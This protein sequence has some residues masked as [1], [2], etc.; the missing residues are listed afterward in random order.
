MSKSPI[1]LNFWVMPNAG[2]T[3]RLILE[4]EIKNFQKR[5]PH[6]HIN[7]TIHPWSKAWDALMSFVKNKTATAAP[8]IVQIGSTWSGT[9]TYLGVLQNITNS[10][11]VQGRKA[12]VRHALESGFYP[13]TD[14]LYSIPWFLDIRVLYFRHDLLKK[15]KKEPADLDTWE[16]FR[17]VC[18]AL[19]KLSKKKSTLY[20]LRL[21]G[22][23]AGILVHDIAPWIWGAGGDFLSSDRK[24]SQFSN[25]DAFFGIQWYFSLIQSGI[26]P[27]ISK[28]GFVPPGNFFSGEYAMQFSGI[29]PLQIFTNPRVPDYNATVAKEYGVALFPRGRAG[30]WTFF[31]GSNLGITS[32]SK[33]PAEATEFMQYLVSS[34]SQE[35]H[36][37]AIGMFPSVKSAF[38]NMAAL[39]PEVGSVFRESL[40]IAR[41]LPSILSLGTIEQILGATTEQVLQLLIRK[42]YTP[43]LLKTEIQRAAR[44]ANYILSLYET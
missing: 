3:T 21:S 15:I 42:K 2:F 12:F 22:Q 31:G 37:R 17:E 39:K 7:L 26:I 34:E 1:T 13:G 25:P 30:R 16:G 6:Y 11:P 41:L 27:V 18:T 10:F 43:E 35:R 4:K 14:Q 8:D 24:V 40:N 23:K 5:H 19:K 9:L 20:P 33:Y 28:E 38:D 36:G 32:F 29:W 44:E